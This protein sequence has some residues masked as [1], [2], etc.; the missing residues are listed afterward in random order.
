[1]KKLL[2]L[3]VI[4]IGMV[5]CNDGYVVETC[6]YEPYYEAPYYHYYY[7]DYYP[8]RWYYYNPRPSR[9]V[10]TP[11]KP[12]PPPRMPKHGNKPSVPSNNKGGRR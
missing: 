12:V 8:R 2:L 7:R 3:L 4:L 9:P 6:Y 10:I 1:M 5:S 11:N